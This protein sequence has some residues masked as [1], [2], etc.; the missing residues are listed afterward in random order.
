VSNSNGDAVFTVT[1]KVPETVT[2]TGADTTDS[3]SGWTVMVTYTAVVTTPT[4]TTTTTAT[5]TTANG[6][7]AATADTTGTGGTGTGAASAT[8]T[9][10]ATDTSATSP[11][12]AFTGAP[13][14]LPYIFGLGAM[15]LALGTFGRVVLAARRRGQ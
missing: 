11:T 5:S 8:G 14:A 13:A 1:D 10:G 4:T 3:I 15:L 12:L 6:A 9:P 2:Y 7:A